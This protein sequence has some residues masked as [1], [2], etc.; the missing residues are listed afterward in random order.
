M[1]INTLA[2]FAL[3]LAMVGCET[4]G[5]TIPTNTTVEPE[6]P[7]TTAADP[8]HAAN[9]LA[10]LSGHWKGTWGNGTRSTLAIGGTLDAPS[11]QYCFG[12]DCWD[13]DDAEITDNAIA[14]GD[15]RR[16]TF[17]LDGTVLRG[18]LH[19]RNRNR[20]WKVNMGRAD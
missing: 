16:F 20:T 12:D 9:P 3:A 8:A 11:A 13:V 5:T 17:R 15:N 4:T 2:V 19:D 10:A 6:Q 14:W 18:E 1:R 7:T